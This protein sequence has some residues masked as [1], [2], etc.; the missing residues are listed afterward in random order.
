MEWQAIWD[1][2]SQLAEGFLLTLQLSAIAILLG[3]TVG[4]VAALLRTSRFRPVVWMIE[5]YV[6]LFRGT[7]LLMQLFFIYFG[8]PI[9]GVNVDRFLS[10]VAALTL[11]SGAYISEIVRAGIESVARG[12]RDAAQSLGF[13]F[14]QTM[15]HVVIPQAGLVALPPL[16]G[17]YISVVKD[18]SLAT[19]IGYSELLRGAQGIIDRTAR[20]IEVYLVVGLLYFAICY[21]LSRAAARLEKRALVTR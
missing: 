7:P 15:R 3:S 16:V 5:G 17:F 10:V 18:T 14:A 20:P 11:Y 4:L 12:Q 8:L 6:G 9:L 19:I 13:T 1:S 21:P 2:R